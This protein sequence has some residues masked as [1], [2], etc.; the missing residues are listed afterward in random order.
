MRP[1]LRRTLGAVGLVTAV[2]GAFV[3]GVVAG[4]A[5]KPAAPAAAP[6][7][8][9][10]DA[11]RQIASQALTPVDPATLDAAAIQAMLRAAGDQWGTWTTEQRG[12]GVTAGYVGIGVWL[13]TGAH[14]TVLVAQVSDGSTA[15]Q[16]GVRP[17]DEVRAVDGRP[18]ARLSA[19]VVASLLRGPSGTSVML[20]TRRGSAVR[21]IRL[22]RTAVSPPGVSVSLEPGT[23]A[24]MSVGRIIVPVFTRG[25]GRQ[26]RT[27]LLRLH[28]A[29]ASGV[30]L[31][32]RGNPGGLLDEG[33][34]TASAFLD[35]GTVVTYARRDG[36]QQ[37]LAAVAGGDTHMP[38]VV[39]VDGGTAS[40]AEVVAGALQDRGRAVLVGSRTFGKGSVQE[41]RLLTDGSALELT[42]ARYRTPSGRDLDGVG[43]EPDIEVAPGSAPDVAV[44][45][46]VE[47]LTGLVADTAPVAG[48]R[49]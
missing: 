2:T 19:P 16:A 13:R 8:P 28:A 22:T 3:T 49:G 41:P 27:A 35:G 47:V 1:V 25:A 5:S 29:H 11:A 40:A 33:V 6:L 18:T 9:L 23:D 43:L 36:R 34:E 44:R 30:I 21:T 26:V 14:L 42:V 46:A 48:G 24:R 31:D 39:L 45:R 17:G 12:P 20:T 10:D 15:A 4:A 38:L 7:N 37:R 32:L